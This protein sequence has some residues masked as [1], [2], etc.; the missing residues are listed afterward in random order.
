M[1]DQSLRLMMNRVIKRVKNR[2]AE[3]LS[4]APHGFGYLSVNGKKITRRWRKWFQFWSGL[5]SGDVERRSKDGLKN[6]LGTYIPEA[7]FDVKKCVIRKR[8]STD[9]KPERCALLVKLIAEMVPEFKRDDIKEIPSIV[10]GMTNKT[11]VKTEEIPDKAEIQASLGHGGKEEVIAIEWEVKPEDI[12]DDKK[13]EGS[14]SHYRRG[15]FG[16]ESSRR[17]GDEGYN[18]DRHRGSSNL[19]R[20]GQHGYRGSRARY[21]GYNSDRLR[22]RTDNRFRGGQ[23]GYRGSIDGYRGYNGDRWRGSIYNRFYP[24]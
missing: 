23:Y 22:G 14:N 15:Q 8:L 12:L 11:K 21:E 24:Y 9:P 5:T 1:Y 4:Q 17:A 16:F 19:F 7:I 13:V 2:F 10:E 3:N 20:G 18:F 6:F